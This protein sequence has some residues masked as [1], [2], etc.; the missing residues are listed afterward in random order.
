MVYEGLWGD[1]TEWYSVPNHQSNRRFFFIRAYLRFE[2]ARIWGG[3]DTALNGIEME[4][5]AWD[6]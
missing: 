3:D 5:I 4:E 1:W 6:I 2:N